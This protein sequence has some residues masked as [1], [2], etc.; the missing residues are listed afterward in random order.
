MSCRHCYID[1][2]ALIG[3]LCDKICVWTL[4][5]L[6]HVIFDLQRQPVKLKWWN[7]CLCCI[8]PP[9]NM[10]AI[11]AAIAAAAVAANANR[12]NQLKSKEVWCCSVAIKKILEI[13]IL[14][15]HII[16]LV[17][18]SLC[19]LSCP[20]CNDPAFLEW[21]SHLSSGRGPVES[22]H[23]VSRWYLLGVRYKILTVRIG[24]GKRKKLW[25][26]L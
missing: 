17:A 13:L 4:M 9:A 1:T 2:W 14:A 23:T 24:R 15:D 26:Q 22:V 25:I 6:L 10:L 11:N 8:Y 16:S 19:Y 5:P 21:P 12:D 20:I 7:P 3:G 18:L